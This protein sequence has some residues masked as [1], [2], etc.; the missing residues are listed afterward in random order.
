MPAITKPCNCLPSVEQWEEVYA[1]LALKD[2]RIR[3]LKRALMAI[4]N[5]VLES[6]VPTA[7]PALRKDSALGRRGKGGRR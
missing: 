5:G 2:R 3:A 1:A 6:E 4:K 7:G